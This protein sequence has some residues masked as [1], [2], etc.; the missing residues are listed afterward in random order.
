MHR[1]FVQG[2]KATGRKLV[3]VTSATVA[4]E[5]LA[6]LSVAHPGWI[7]AGAGLGAWLGGHVARRC[8][9]R[10]VPAALLLAAL[11]SLGLA[12]CFAEA[13][14]TLVAGTVGLGVGMAQPAAMAWGARL[15]SS[16]R[17]GL[18]IGVHGVAASAG[19]AGAGALRWAA[20]SGVAFVVVATLCL[21]L[22]LTLRGLDGPSNFG[23]SQHGCSGVGVSVIAGALRYGVVLSLPALASSRW[24][25]VDD[26]AASIFAVGAA[27]AVGLKLAVT[28]CSDRG[29]PRVVATMFGLGLCSVSTAFV[30]GTSATAGWAASV[31]LVATSTAAL[32]LANV[33][34]VGVGDAMPVDPYRMGRARAMQL[35]AGAGCAA[36]LPSASASLVHALLLTLPLAFVACA[37]LQPPRRSLR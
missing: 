3:A 32:S 2:C 33:H 6:A 19:V 21:G 5:T 36:V 28:A 7:V 27:A 10:L 14:H 12:W 9:S 16:R 35:A 29:A 31:G 20:P 1:T 4:L 22:A 23:R 18:A 17:R 30:L 26:Q 13:V 8:V 34:A 37:L 25:L 24:G 11:G 15:A